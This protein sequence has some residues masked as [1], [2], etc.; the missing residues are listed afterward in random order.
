MRLGIVGKKIGMTQ[1]FNETGIRVPV[2][3][4]DASGCF[5]TQVKSKETDGYNAIQIGSGEK[6]P[7]NVKKPEAG[8]FK[9]ATVK[10]CRRVEEIRLSDDQDMSAFKAG[11]RLSVSMFQPGDSVDVCGTTKGKGFQGVMRK[12]GFSGKPQTHGTS[13]YFRHGGSIG[14]A[15]FPG[16][17][18]KN[19]KMPGQMGNKTKTVQNLQIVAIRPEDGL[20]LIRGA[21]P[22]ANKEFVRIRPATKKPIP[23]GERQYLA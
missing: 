22:G 23:E 5:V 14:C 3:V 18:I 16:R 4:I 11:A 7:Q 20:I 9:K 15:T 17:V 21:I 1:I 2:T 8:H 10:A 19:R 12:Y 13:K 6:K